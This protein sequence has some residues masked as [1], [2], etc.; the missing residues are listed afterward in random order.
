MYIKSKI[1]FIIIYKLLQL[2]IIFAFSSLK[3]CLKKKQKK[4]K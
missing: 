3:A 1:V 2:F 4:K